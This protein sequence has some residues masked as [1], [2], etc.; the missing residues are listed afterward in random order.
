MELKTKLGFVVAFLALV[1][2][3]FIVY[4]YIEEKNT[5]SDKV[6]SLSDYYTIS[7]DEAMVVMDGVVYEK[8]ALVENGHPYFDM[9]TVISLFNHRFYWDKSAKLLVFTT[10]DQVVKI[11]P[12]EKNY[13]VNRI[14]TVS[15]YPLAKLSKDTIYISVEYLA[16]Y[17]DFTY[18]YY[19]EPNRLMV[20]YQWGEYLY[21]DVQKDTQIRVSQDI[22]SDILKQV[23]AGDKLMV[24][25]GG[26]IQQN[27]FIKMMSEDGVR[28]YVLQQD[29][30]EAQHIKIESK[31]VPQEYT[32]Q[33]RSKTIY[34]GWQLIY[35]Q[36]NLSYLESAVK[37]ADCLNVVS[38]TW[39][40][41]TGTDGELLSYANHEYVT[42]A[43]E[44]GIEVWALYKNDT[45]E[46]LFTCTEDSLKLLKSTEKREKL[47]DSMIESATEYNVD[48]I[49]IDFEMLSTETG[50]HFIQ[51]LRELSVSCRAEGLVLSV[52]NYVP[53]GYNAYYDL[54][55]QGQI[56]DYIVIMGYDEHYNGSAEAGSVSSI[57]FFGNAI[58]DTL[59]MVPAEKII[60]GV[61]FYTRLWKEVEKDGEITVTV[62]ATPNMDGADEQV[63]AFGI[64]PEWDEET[65]QYYA[66]YTKKGA[67]YRIWLEEEESLSAKA[68]LIAEAELAGIAAWKL[69]DEREGIWPM[70]KSILEP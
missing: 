35:T 3:G 60:M 55:E 16:Q 14:S 8:N 58:K 22:K 27:G 34:M 48:G 43:H 46:N 31:Y 7:A 57:G 6:M 49:N 65:A 37:K 11:K 61:P 28:G 68:K 45:M 47:I 12:D 21:A 26:G 40:F 10:P 51:F 19:P 56:V 66:E 20:N 52:D 1:V 44:L 54:K 62:E 33:L 50:P 29:L 9:D 67:L 30:A 42:K 24:I 5:P 70:L 18:S 25:D 53:A 69:G 38:P 59:A 13:F 23:K 41:L 15:D 64:E 39:F 4:F 63:A 32:P 2:V 36:D 17:A